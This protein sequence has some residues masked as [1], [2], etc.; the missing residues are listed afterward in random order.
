MNVKQ[1]HVPCNNTY[2]INKVSK[3]KPL[4]LEVPFSGQHDDPVQ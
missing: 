4:H 3:N 1:C 2:E